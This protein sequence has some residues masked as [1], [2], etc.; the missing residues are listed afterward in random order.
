MELNLEEGSAYDG[1][2][3]WP[4]HE[5]LRTDVSTFAH[6]FMCID[7]NIEVYGS[8]NSAKAQHLSIIFKKCDSAVR[9]CKS[10][11]EIERYT[12]RK[13]LVTLQNGKRFVLDQYNEKKIMRESMISWN[14]VSS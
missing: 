12:R 8:Y 6:K 1:K 9:T 13:F 4:Y 11:E 3:F 14:S 10:D 5:S 2:R 7:Q